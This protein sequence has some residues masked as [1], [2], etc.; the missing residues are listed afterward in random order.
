MDRATHISNL[1]SRHEL[2][3]L[4]IQK[5]SDDERIRLEESEAVGRRF[6]EWR[7]GEDEE[8]TARERLEEVLGVV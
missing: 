8:K 6:L 7:I 5:L 4:N 3:E 1:L 2:G